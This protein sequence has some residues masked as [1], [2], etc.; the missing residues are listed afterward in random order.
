VSLAAVVLPVLGVLAMIV[1]PVHL[2]QE[3]TRARRAEGS[4]PAATTTGEHAPPRRPL[5]VAIFF[6]LSGVLLPWVTGLAVKIYLDVIG[7]PT[8][9]VSSFLDPVA[10]PIFLVLTLVFWAFPFVLLAS[11]LV[12][13]WRVGFPSGSKEC[14]STLPLWMAFWAGALAA[15]PVFGSVFVDFDALMTLVPVGTILLVPMALGYWLGW[16]ILRRRRMPVRL[17]R[18]A[19]GGHP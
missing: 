4:Q 17:S 6:V 2:L 5:G 18:D 13:P 14:E 15:I 19:A 10:T 8:Y 1:V 3:R 9:P 11:A 12:I 7:A 16:W